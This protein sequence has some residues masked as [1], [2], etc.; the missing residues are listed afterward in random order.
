MSELMSELMN[1]AVTGRVSGA[2]GA[3]GIMTL[4]LA[5]ELGRADVQDVCDLLAK[6]TEKGP[7]QVVIDF[8]GVIH[9]DYRGVKPL[10]RRA[11]ALRELG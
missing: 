9:F 2:T 3:T 10:M 6:L 8:S 1:Q 11:E 5:G 4:A 7:F